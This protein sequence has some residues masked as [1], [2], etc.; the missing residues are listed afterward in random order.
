MPRTD[1]GLNLRMPVLQPGS[2][3]VQTQSGFDTGRRVFK[4]DERDIALY[5]PD[6][7][8]PD[9]N[10]RWRTRNGTANGTYPYMFVSSTSAG[11]GEN[12][13][14][15]LTVNYLGLIKRT[16]L[17]RAYE[18]LQTQTTPVVSNAFSNR[19]AISTPIVNRIYVSTEKPDP[20]QPGKKSVP[21]GWP[22]NI[23]FDLDISGIPIP[24]NSFAYW[25]LR[26]R[27]H[28]QAGGLYEVTDQHVYEVLLGAGAGG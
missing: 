8:T 2:N 15:E 9:T 10:I 24:N 18:T 20:A 26:E 4:L 19:I 5:T 16:P 23:E 22:K 1:H 6:L 21:P 12:G 3:F 14:V 13:I 27:S 28:K 17:K 7:E 25:I 11:E